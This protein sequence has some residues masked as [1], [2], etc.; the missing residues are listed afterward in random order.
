MLIEVN[1]ERVFERVKKT[2]TRVGYICILK[3]KWRASFNK[4]DTKKDFAKKVFHLHLRQVGDDETRY[5]CAYLN[6]FS[7]VAKAYKQLKL[8]LWEKYPNQRDAYTETKS[9]F[10]KK[11][12]LKAKEVGFSYV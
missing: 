1:D 9:E 5:F 2:W 3:K 11:Y 8:K 4:G 7:E 10:V 6:Q 12:M